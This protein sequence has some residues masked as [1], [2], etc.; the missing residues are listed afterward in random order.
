MAMIVDRE[1]YCDVCMYND[2]VIVPE[3][4]ECVCMF[5]HKFGTCCFRDPDPVE[6]Y[7]AMAVFKKE[8][9]EE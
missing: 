7:N 9:V 5:F 2:A 1:H 3:T 6:L 8:G 4:E